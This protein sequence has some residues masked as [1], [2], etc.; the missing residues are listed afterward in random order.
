MSMTLEQWFVDYE[1]VIT[2]LLPLI[3]NTLIHLHLFFRTFR[4][5]NLEDIVSQKES[6]DLIDFQ[7]LIL[8]QIARAKRHL[9]KFWYGGIQNIYFEV[10]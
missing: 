2:D 6:W 7:N 9:Y 4:L 1:Y 10:K 8:R 5:F 3:P